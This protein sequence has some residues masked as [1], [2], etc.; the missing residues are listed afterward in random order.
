MQNHGFLHV[1]YGQWRLAPA[2]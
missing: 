1:E 2:S